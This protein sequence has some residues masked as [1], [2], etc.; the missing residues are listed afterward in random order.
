MAKV[1][2]NSGIVKSDTVTVA[3]VTKFDITINPVIMTDA[4]IGDTW[5]VS[6]AGSKSWSGSLECFY[7]STDTTGQGAMDTGDTVALL[8]YPE[9]ATVG[10]QEFVGNAV[11]NSVAVSNAKDAYITTTI[12]FTGDGALT[13]VAM[14]A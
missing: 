3:E 2:G 5:G 13:Y 6:T 10:N 12:T 7:D 8:L 14:P 11:I 9:G 1:L 4:A